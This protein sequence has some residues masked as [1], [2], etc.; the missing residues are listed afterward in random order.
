[1]E[2]CKMLTLK[3]TIKFDKYNVLLVKISLELS[4]YII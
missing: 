4:V 3:I 2:I 1:M